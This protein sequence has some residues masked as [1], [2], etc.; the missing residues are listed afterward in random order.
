MFAIRNNNNEL[1]RSQKIST[2][3]PSYWRSFLPDEKLGYSEGYMVYDDFTQ[4]NTE[5]DMYA[6]LPKR[7]KQ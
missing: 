7:K 1:C 4:K 6:P 3:H 5:K 2:M